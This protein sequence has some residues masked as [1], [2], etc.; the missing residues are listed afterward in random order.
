MTT[1]REEKLLDAL[2]RI[3]GHETRADRR[4]PGMVDYSEVET[5]RRIARIAIAEGK[6]EE[7]TP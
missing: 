6:K 1:K 3:A 2:V 4:H 7:I 5:L